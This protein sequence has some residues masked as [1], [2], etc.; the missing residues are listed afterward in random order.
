[1]S[2]VRFIVFITHSEELA[3]SHSLTLDLPV[4]LQLTI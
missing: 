4:S 1:M 2:L 3:N